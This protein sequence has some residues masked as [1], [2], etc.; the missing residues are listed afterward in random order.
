MKA[1]EDITACF[2]DHCG[3]YLPW[4]QELSQA[5]KRVLYVDPNEEAFERVN[6]N[7]IGE[8]FPEDPRFEKIDD[9]WL[10]KKEVDLFIFPDSNIKSVGTQIE[11]E[12][13]GYPVWGSRRSI[14]LEQ[15]R[16][17]FV[18][19]LEDLGL[20]VPKYKRVVG[21]SA[22]R[23]YLKSRTNQIIKVSRYRRTM[24]TYHWRSWDDDEGWLDRKAVDLGGIKELFPFLV[25]ESIDTPFELGG[26]TYCVKG[27]FPTHMLDGYEWKDKGYLS[28]FKRVVDA[29]PQTQ[30]VMEAFGPILERAGHA[31][32]W[33]ME[34]RVKNDQFY[35]IDPTP[36]APL[37]GSASQMMLYKNIPEIIAAGAEGSLV[38]PEPAAK[39]SAECI[40]TL[41]HK[42]QDWASVKVPE[43]LKPWMKLGGSCTVNGRT[44]FP[45]CDG[46]DTEDIGWLVALGDSPRET[47]ETMLGYKALLPE[48]VTAHT[49]SLIDLLRE[50]Q[51]A[52]DDGIEFTPMPVPEPEVVVTADE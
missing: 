35:F 13:Q 20:E 4:A 3:L 24:E 17:A 18:K 28:A 27:K 2:V 29:P 49:E 5:Y 31:N 34:M 40:L 19:V 36:R 14:F 21:V 23:E 9:L 10:H 16:E 11:L 42:K 25:F 46:D 52:E 32:F 1:I 44:W 51:K 37:P 47:I 39:F 43:E 41:T 7:V 15:S 38:E 12:S 45:P 30:A 33:S 48:G 50:I 6:E 8:S 26:D 22:L